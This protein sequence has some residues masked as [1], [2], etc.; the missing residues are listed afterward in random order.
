MNTLHKI[1]GEG[2]QRLA[3]HITVRSNQRPAHPA[4]KSREET[5][6]GKP[7]QQPTNALTGSYLQKEVRS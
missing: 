1:E 4:N 3:H 7:T 5:K 6:M 2:S